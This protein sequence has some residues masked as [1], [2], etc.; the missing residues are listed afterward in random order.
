MFHV[1]RP[2]ERPK[3]LRSN[4]FSRRVRRSGASSSVQ[5]PERMAPDE[6]KSAGFAPRHRREATTDPATEHHRGSGDHLVHHPDGPK[7]S[8]PS[9]TTTLPTRVHPQRNTSPQ[10]PARAYNPPNPQRPHNPPS[11]HSPQ[12]PAVN[13]TTLNPTAAPTQPTDTHHD[14]ATPTIHD[15]AITATR[16]SRRYIPTPL[17][18]ISGKCDQSTRTQE[19]S[20]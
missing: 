17:L 4:R 1:K 5:I 2:S 9:T 19:T 8:A 11:P 20:S 13:P 6:P 15:R 16:S 12:R 14:T 18:P 10:R 3:H 7:T